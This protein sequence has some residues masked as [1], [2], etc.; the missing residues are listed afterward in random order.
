M[1][2]RLVALLAALA[3]A[4]C[5]A[6]GCGSA[7]APAVSAGPI[8]PP[9]SSWVT[10]EPPLSSLQGYRTLMDRALQ[11]AQVHD[12]ARAQEL[13]R[14]AAAKRAA[15]LRARRDALRKYL[16]AKRRAERLYKEAL[17]KAA[18]ERKKQQAALR[19]ARLERARR[20]RE[21]MK[22]LQVKPGEECSLPEVAAEY[23]CESG[24]LPFK[25][26]LKPK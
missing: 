25:G 23:H 11:L 18:L 9:E 1:T 6:S 2:S 3:L 26:S 22:K 15:R 7:A 10:G 19:K 16:E 20:L 21:L 13:A 5:V 17:H 4:A 12:A 14:I 24:R 8:G